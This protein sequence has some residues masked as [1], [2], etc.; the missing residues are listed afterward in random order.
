[1]NLKYI[2]TRLSSNP[3]LPL[4]STHTQLFIMDATPF[5]R[6]PAELRNDIYTLALR[7]SKIQVSADHRHGKPIVQRG[8]QRDAKNIM[9]LTAV[10]K[11]AG[12]ESLGIFYASNELILLAEVFSRTNHPAFKEIAAGRFNFIRTWL[13]QIGPKAR[14]ALTNVKISLGGWQNNHEYLRIDVE[15]LSLVFLDLRSE[16][17]GIGD[18]ITLNVVMVRDYGAMCSYRYGPFQVPLL[19]DWAAE[20]IKIRAIADR[21]ELRLRPKSEGGKFKKD[22]SLFEPMRVDAAIKCHSDFDKFMA[23]ME[24]NARNENLD[25]AAMAFRG[26]VLAEHCE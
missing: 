18:A 8:R 6:L 16:L 12:R 13:L 24:S 21:K 1:M 20:R 3:R 22:H 7:T 19:G 26:M 5:A 25:D 2:W 23:R 14:N 4:F 9:A 15:R 10:C 11:Q 17:R